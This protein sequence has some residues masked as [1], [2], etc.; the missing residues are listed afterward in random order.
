MKVNTSKNNN[1]FQRLSRFRE[2]PVLKALD[3]SQRIPKEPQA[4]F[5]PHDDSLPKPWE[6]PTRYKPQTYTQPWEEP[7]RY[8]PITH[9]QTWE[10]PDRYEPITRPAPESPQAIP[11]QNS[12]WRDLLNLAIKIASIA[13]AFM[14]ITTFLYGLH[15]NTDPSMNPMIKDGDLLMFYRLDKDYAIGDL[16]VLDYKGKRQTRR[17]VA[18]AGD[19]VDITESG[20]IINNAIQQEPEIYQQTRRYDNGLSL[21]L[22]V[23]EGQVFVL[24]D[25]REN[26][27]DSRV[28]GPVDVKDTLGTVITV[29][30]RRN[31]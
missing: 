12:V 4:K 15:R 29:L 10:E 2:D 6:K 24:G 23:G 17:V 8:E 3:R 9:T 26:A 7:N 28:Y 31:L 5:Y 22:I 14:L 25:A 16:L 27:T 1:Y 11:Q 13:I 20:L 21:P 30:R 19:T 18:R